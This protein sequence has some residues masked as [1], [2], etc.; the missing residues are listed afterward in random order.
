MASFLNIFD[1]NFKISNIFVKSLIHL[2]DKHLL[3][4]DNSNLE[5]LKKIFKEE[6]NGILMLDNQTA[7]IKFLSKN[8]KTIFL[9]KFE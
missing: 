4:W 8:H 5:H 9:L 6:F 3:N 7:K 1:Q 2:H